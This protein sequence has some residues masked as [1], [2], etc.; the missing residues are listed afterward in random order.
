MLYVRYAKK[1]PKLYKLADSSDVWS[2]GNDT[3]RDGKLKSVDTQVKGPLQWPESLPKSKF[4]SDVFEKLPKWCV[5]RLSHNIWSNS[6]CCQ[7][8]W[9]GVVTRRPGQESDQCWIRRRESRLIVNMTAS[10][11]RK[12]RRFMLFWESWSGRR[13]A[14]HTTKI[15][16]S[17]PHIFLIPW[18][19]FFT[20]EKNLHF[21]M[22]QS[23]SC[24]CL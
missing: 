9:D 11:F 4:L 18:P 1:F 2:S 13:S 5:W 19:Q 14:F 21:L 22:E 16:S 15:E 12:G 20:K 17:W 6:E 7:S 3:G 10:Y 24:T 8:V 23:Y